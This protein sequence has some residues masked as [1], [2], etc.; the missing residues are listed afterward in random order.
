MITKEWCCPL[1]G[2][3]VEPAPPSFAASLV[4]TAAEANGWQPNSS[5]YPLLTPRQGC[6]CSFVLGN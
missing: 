3:V 6:S 1:A 5:Q 4:A 2:W